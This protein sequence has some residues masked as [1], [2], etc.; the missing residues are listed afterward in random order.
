M[1]PWASGS[2]PPHREGASDH[3]ALGQGLRPTPAQVAH[4]DDR[5]ETALGGLWQ[6]SAPADSQVYISA[7]WA[8]WAVTWA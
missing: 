6:L 4:W 7:H 5:Q 3:G 1:L 8:A 2:S